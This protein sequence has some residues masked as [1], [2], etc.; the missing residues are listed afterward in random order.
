MKKMHNTST[1]F[2]RASDENTFAEKSL[3]QTAQVSKSHSNNVFLLAPEVLRP[4]I[5]STLIECWSSQGGGRGETLELY[6]GLM[7]A[8]P[9]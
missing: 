3:P 1:R 6:S 7:N 9:I 4:L 8:P 2:Q 5:R